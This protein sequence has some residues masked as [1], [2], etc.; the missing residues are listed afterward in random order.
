MKTLIAYYSRTGNNKKI[1]EKLR[2]KLGCDI[3]EIQEEG[4]PGL[5]KAG[6]SA[7]LKKKTK[8]KTE[9]NPENYDL[10]VV[11][12]PIWGG[13]ITP[14]ARTYLQE[15]SDKIKEVAF[16]SVSGSGEENKKALEDFEKTIGKK[17]KAALLLKD[18][19]EQEK[20]LEKF[21]E[22]LKD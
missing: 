17:T 14:A 5:L 4:K 15:N 21:A 18:K 10:T 9:K 19:E 8:I 13:V 7:L 20:K 3:D 12:S 22:G 11:V 2:E 6:L 1:A 16:L